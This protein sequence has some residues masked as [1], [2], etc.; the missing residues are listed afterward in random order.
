[1]VGFPANDF[2]NQETKD[3]Q[4]IAAFRQ[5]NYG[6]SFPLMAKSVVIKS[7]D[8][9]KKVLEDKIL[10]PQNLK[11][12]SAFRS[13]DY[14]NNQL[15]A[16]TSDE[17]AALFLHHIKSYEYDNDEMKLFDIAVKQLISSLGYDDIESNFE[18]DFSHYGDDSYG[19]P[20]YFKTIIESDNI[21]LAIQ[22]HIQK[23]ILND[24]IEIFD[25]ETPR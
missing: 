19:D 16:T 22:D 5:K 12:T 10:K 21:E 18:C 4:A 17:K 1:M 3:D 20:N 13:I 15:Y 7:K 9:N 2:K 24:D 25:I 8:Q 23:V 11:L 6:V 14:Q